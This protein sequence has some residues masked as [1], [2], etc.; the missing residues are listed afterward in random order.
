MAELEFTDFVELLPGVR[1]GNSHFRLQVDVLRD[2]GSITSRLSWTRR[3]ARTLV[4]LGRTHHLAPGLL[5]SRPTA[6]ADRAALAQA[7]KQSVRWLRLEDFPQ[8]WEEVEQSLGRTIP[9]P[10]HARTADGDDWRALYDVAL[11]AKVAEIY[12]PDVEM[13]GYDAP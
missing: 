3:A 13:F 5:R 9:F 1:D 2:A 12:R 11:Q 10:W 4:H 6:A 7:R 8:A